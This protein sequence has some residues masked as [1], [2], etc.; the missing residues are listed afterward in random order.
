M[1]KVFINGSTL[2]SIANA[3][4]SKNGD[5]NTY[6][7]SEMPQAILDIPSGGGNYQEKTITPTISQQNVLPDTELGYDA[8]SKVV[9]NAV[10]SSIDSDIQAGNIKHGVDILGVVGTYTG[11]IPQPLVPP[12][13]DKNYIY[14]QAEEDNSSISLQTPKN[15]SITLQYSNDGVNWSS[16]G[17]TDDNVYR[18]FNTIT[19]SQRGDY[20]FLRGDNTNFGTNDYSY[21]QFKMTGKVAS[22][23]NIMSLLDSTVVSV[24]LSGK[25]FCFFSF[26]KGCE[27]LTTAPI[28]SATTLS[29]H[30]Y[31]YMFW[32]CYSLKTPPMLPA[33]TL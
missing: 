8:L 31:R 33:T 15:L 32:G 17:Y 21:S 1:S 22:G 10:T 6:Y 28:L 23:G 14:F 26:F 20:V 5:S 9:V 29:Q 30:C 16:W 11:D 27:S 2:T 19:L 3:I 25:D 7:P 4:R 24:S 18:N 12:V 13:S